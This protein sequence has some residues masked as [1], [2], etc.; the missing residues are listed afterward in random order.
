MVFNLYYWMKLTLF[1]L[2]YLNHSNGFFVM[3][4]CRFCQDFACKAVMVTVTMLLVSL[5]HCVHAW[6]I[7][8]RYV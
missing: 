3:L 6:I 4:F 1:V 5:S 8:Q 7:A 2:F